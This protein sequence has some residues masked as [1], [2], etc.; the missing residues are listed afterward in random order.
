MPL[1]NAYTQAHLADYLKK[2]LGTVADVLN[3]NVLDF[4]IVDAIEEAL[5]AYGVDE[6]SEADNIPKLRALARREAWR[7]AVRQLATKYDISTPSGFS[8]NRSQLQQMAEKALA[9]AVEDCRAY[10]TRLMVTSVAV[11]RSHPYPV[12]DDDED[13]FSA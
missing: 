6:V 5:I 2:H 13:E 4:H 12:A 11:R 1:P 3:W 9:Q 10:D 7:A 8:L